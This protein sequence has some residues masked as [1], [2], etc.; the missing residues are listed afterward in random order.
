MKKCALIINRYGGKGILDKDI[1]KLEKI[2]LENHYKTE[3]HFT[4][5]RGDGT[6]I[7]KSLKDNIDLAISIGGDGTFSE[8]VRGNV[9]REK[10]LVISH[11][12]NGTT[13]DMAYSFGLTKGLFNNLYGILN[14]NIFEI[15]VPS[16]NDIPFVY[17]CGYGKFL[18]IPYDTP[19]KYKKVWGKLAY[20]GY[21]F[22]DFFKKLKTYD[23]TY[24]IDDFELSGSYSLIIISNSTTI[25]GFRNFYRS[26]ELND[27][28]VEIALLDV[29]KRRLLFKNMLQMLFASATGA[30]D[31]I[32]YTASKFTMKFAEP[33][34]TKWDLDGEE[35][36]IQASEYIF[37]C[38]YKTKLLMPFQVKE[39]KTIN[40][41][42]F[43]RVKK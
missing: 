8:I 1:E 33:M 9:Q 34:R 22:I 43:K 41:L 23:I 37:E 7:I 38:K 30:S 28:K 24:N 20:Y 10:P 19:Q 31:A 18:D 5:C 16:V 14:G 29:N 2:L 40:L 35:K 4:K 32:R 42:P 12:P 26:V 39:R 21:G 25:A 11:L 17:V 3:I 36:E 6:D 27:G 15:D 13:N